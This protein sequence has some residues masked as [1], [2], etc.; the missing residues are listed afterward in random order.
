M[1]GDIAIIRLYV[2]VRNRVLVVLVHSGI[3]I[4]TGINSRFSFLVFPFRLE[5]LRFFLF[6]FFDTQLRPLRIV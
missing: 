6:C 1:F 5:L 2:H 4:Y 3:Y